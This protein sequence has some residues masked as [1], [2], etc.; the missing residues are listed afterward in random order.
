MKSTSML[1]GAAAFAALQ[2]TARRELDASD[3]DDVYDPDGRAHPSV[4][5]IIFRPPAKAT[6]VSDKP[7]GKR[8]RRRQRGRK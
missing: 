5:P 3:V 1:I 4:R 6:F 7:L 8:A 2:D